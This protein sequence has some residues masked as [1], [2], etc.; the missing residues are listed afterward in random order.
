MRLI[1]IGRTRTYSRPP[2]DGS[3]PPSS[4]SS[5]TSIFPHSW[6]RRFRSLTDTNLTFILGYLTSFRAQHSGW[7]CYFVRM[8]HVPINVKTAKLIRPFFRVATHISPF[9]VTNFAWENVDFLFLAII[10]FNVNRKI[11]KNFSIPKKKGSAWKSTFNCSDF[12]C[13]GT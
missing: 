4:L 6:A 11:R 12:G 5:C 10:L 13:K 3:L 1:L 7:S 8:S 2:E 9:K